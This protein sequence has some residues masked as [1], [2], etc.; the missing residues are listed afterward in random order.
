MGVRRGVE[1]DGEAEVGVR[2]GEE[3]EVVDGEAG[4]DDIFSRP[5]EERRAKRERS[6]AGKE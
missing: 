1:V 5:V 2:R 3:E 4:R 6:M